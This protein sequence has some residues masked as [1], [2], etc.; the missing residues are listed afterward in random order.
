MA[1]VFFSPMLAE[2]GAEAAERA[3][4]PLAAEP[5]KWL[6]EPKLDGLR[7]IAVRRGEEVKLYS[8]NRLSY[9]ERFPELRR[10]L[11]SSPVDNFVLDG[12]VVAGV[13]G[14][15]DFAALQ[16]GAG[17]ATYMVFDLLWLLGRDLRDLSIEKRKALLDK[18]LPKTAHVRPL[19]PLAG[20]PRALLERACQEGWEGLVAKRAGSVYKAGRSHDWLKLKC[21][22]RQELVVG[23]FTPPRGARAGFGALLVGYWEGDKLAYAGKVGTGFSEDELRRL[24]AKLKELERPTS[25]FATP[26]GEKEARF[27]EPEL[28]AEVTFA[29]WTPDGR[30]RHPSFIA[31]RTDKP[32]RQVVRE[33]C[34]PVQRLG[35]AR[36]LPA[37]ARGDRGRR[38]R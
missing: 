7:C 3:G 24:A 30:L 36:R 38:G 13:G 27:V 19:R 28:V 33:D 5:G 37:G 31:L 18:A 32:A 20:E 6:I 11:A 23:G 14:R 15:A 10:E 8:R 1:A 12:E 34:R 9:D 25:P 22:C 16:E 26:V 2:A 29:E 21:G 4:G 35:G 17:E